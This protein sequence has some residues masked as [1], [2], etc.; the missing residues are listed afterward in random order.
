MEGAYRTGVTA[1]GGIA[2]R[3]FIYAVIASIMVHVL[4][5]LA[6]PS[7]RPAKA[8]PLPSALVARLASPPPVIAPSPLPQP[9]S[10]RRPEPIKPPV[11]PKA[12]ELPPEPLAKPLPSAPRVAAPSPATPSTLDRPRSQEKPAEKVDP[13][14]APPPATVAQPQPS[15]VEPARLPPSPPA[16]ASTDSA[17]PLT[18]GQYRMAIISAARRYKKYPRL[19]I[20]N[21][22]EGQ[23]EIRMMIGADGAIASI[24]IK[25]RSGY[26]VLDQQAL[27]MIR[28]AKPLTP[29]PASLKGRGFSIDIPVMFSLKEET[30]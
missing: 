7:L 21:N 27:E 15:T 14:P 3:T 2:D 19:A 1:H 25:T 12:R 6:L 29:I 22:W 9:P 4:F 23:A 18:L 28:K 30:G 13:V 5:L 10:D 26:E 8:R 11:T 17:D 20:D 24:S 16:A